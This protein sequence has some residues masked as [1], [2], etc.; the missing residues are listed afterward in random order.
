M[1]VSG[2]GSGRPGSVL[3]ADA[4]RRG[5]HHGN[6]ALVRAVPAPAASGYEETH[7]PDGGRLAALGLRT[8]LPGVPGGADEALGADPQAAGPRRDRCHHGGRDLVPARVA[9]CA[10]QLGLPLHLG[11]RGV[12]LELCLPTHRD[13]QRRGGVPRL[14]ADRWFPSW[15][16]R[17]P[18]GG[19]AT[20]CCTATFPRCL[21]TDCRE[22]RAPSCY[23]ASGSWTTWPAR[24]GA[25]R[26]THHGE[27]P[28]PFCLE[29][30]AA[31]RPG[32]GANANSSGT[33]CA[34]SGAV[35]SRRVIRAGVGLGPQMVLRPGG[36]VP[37][38]SR[39]RLRAGTRRIVK[40][41]RIGTCPAGHA[42]RRCGGNVKRAAG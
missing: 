30:P 18:A 15:N 24:A 31:P 38:V 28:G 42:R 6:P 23:A 34:G 29:T 13:S 12:L 33:G 2:A 35:C 39:L 14:G 9:G 3:G 4:A 8:G 7:R 17:S 27:G 36:P 20:D 22:A 32:S 41:E 25:T 10:A 19:P 1:V 11:A 37:H 16:W 5:D 21:R 40:E 26:R